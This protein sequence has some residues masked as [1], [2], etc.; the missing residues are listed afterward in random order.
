MRFYESDLLCPNATEMYMEG[1][2][3]SENFSYVKIAIIGCDLGQ[4]QCAELSSV[5]NLPVNLITLKSHVDFAE[6]TFNEATISY[7]FDSSNY[8]VINSKLVQ[9]VNLYYS[10]A[11]VI[12]DDYALKKFWPPPEVPIFE[13]NTRY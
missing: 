7:S 1:A 6:K 13:F 10:K 2:Y 5:D 12:L 9:K 4:E 3:E 8:L 11:K